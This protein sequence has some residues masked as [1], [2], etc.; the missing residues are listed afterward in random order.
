LTHISTW[1]QGLEGLWTWSFSARPTENSFARLVRE[2]NG[3]L[4][5]PGLSH[6]TGPASP[7]TLV[8]VPTLQ[9]WR[10]ASEQI[11]QSIAIMERLQNLMELVP[12][13]D[14]HPVSPFQIHIP[15]PFPVEEEV[16]Y[17]HLFFM[18]G[19]DLST[20]GVA[21]WIGP[22]RLAPLRSDGEESS[23]GHTVD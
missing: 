21:P 1:R 18:S 19:V 10:E 22:P 20:P 12:C 13:L 16:I 7:G 14:N 9:L 6:L 11:N 17:Q 4:R 8:T 3:T 23:P 15:D 5:T 2:A